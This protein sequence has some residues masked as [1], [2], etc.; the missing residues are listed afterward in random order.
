MESGRPVA[1][2]YAEPCADVRR[3][4]ALECRHRLTLA[5]QA[6]IRRASHTISRV[7]FL[8]LLQLRQTAAALA[9]SCSPPDASASMWSSVSLLRSL[10]YAH[11]P[12]EAANKERHSL[13]EIPRP[14]A[15]RTRAFLAA[16]RAALA[17]GLAPYQRCN[18]ARSVAALRRAYS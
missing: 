13:R 10:Q 11:I 8:E 3:E 1:K 9:K 18:L 16:D 15:P 4:L 7:S 6:A 5:T 12:S 14:G 2:R 17:S